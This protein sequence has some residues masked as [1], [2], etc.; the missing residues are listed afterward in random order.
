[1]VNPELYPWLEIVKVSMIVINMEVPRF[2]YLIPLH[3]TYVF[4]DLH[5]NKL[6]FFQLLNVQVPFLFKYAIDY[7]NNLDSAALVQTAGG[8]VFSVLTA[9]LLGCKSC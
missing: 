1:M 2:R 8:T 4:Y 9:L 6:F 7:L 3:L 5:S